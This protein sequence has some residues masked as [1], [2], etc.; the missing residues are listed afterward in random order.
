MIT[1]ALYM[2]YYKSINYIVNYDDYYYWMSNFQ[3]ID[4]DNYT[5]QFLKFKFKKN[6]VYV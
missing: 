3:P 6:F 1:H 5:R 2:I 4:G